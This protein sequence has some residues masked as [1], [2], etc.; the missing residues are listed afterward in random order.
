MTNLQK[1]IDARRAQ[2]HCSRGHEYTP[3]NTFWNKVQGTR[4]CRICR[5]AAKTAEQNR[6]FYGVTDRDALLAKQGDACPICGITGLTWRKSFTKSWHID[7]PHDKPRTHRGVL[8]AACNIALGRL[9]P[10]WEKAVAYFAFWGAQ[11]ITKS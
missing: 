4:A 5:R 9:E 6:R 2:T 10:Y 8:C 7:H 3:E 1:I 11:D